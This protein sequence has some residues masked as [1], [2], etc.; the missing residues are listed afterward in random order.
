MRRT[1]RCQGAILRDDHILLI[2]HREHAGGRDYWIVPGGVYPRLKTYLCAPLAGEPR[3]GYEPEIEAAQYY[4]IVEVAWFDLRD[5][6]AWGEKVF[7]DRFTYPMVK[8]IQQVLGYTSGRQ[9]KYR[10]R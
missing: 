10:Q 5:E 9:R 3:P 2:K 6:T 7:T 4:A 1:T 8:R